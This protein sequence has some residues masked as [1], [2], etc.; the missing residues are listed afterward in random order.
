MHKP[1][2]SELHA[3]IEGLKV[4][5]A[6]LHEQLVSGTTPGPEHA[7]YNDRAKEYN[8]VSNQLD[9]ALVEMASFEQE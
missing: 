4:K 3:R 2:K 9:R 6:E 7:W 8:T 1:N 5:R